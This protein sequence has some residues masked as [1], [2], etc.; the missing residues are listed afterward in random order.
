MLDTK[1]ITEK[2]NDWFA[3]NA[4]NTNASLEDF[5]G[6]ALQPENT[7]LKS[8]SY[9]KEQPAV[10]NIFKTP[11]GAFDEPAFNTYYGGL[12]K[13]YNEFS[14]EQYD[15]KN[16]TDNLLYSEYDY[17][18]PVKAKI[19]PYTVGITK[20]FNPSSSRI[21]I[22][23]FGTWSDSP[24]SMRE[25]AQ[26]QN[27]KNQKGEDLGF[28][29]NDDSKS[30]MFDFINDQLFG[31]GVK[32]LAQYTTDG[33]HI[34]PFTEES[35]SHKKGEMKYNEMGKPFYETLEGA[36]PVSRQILSPWD[37]ITNDGSNQ[38]KWNFMS[39]DDKDKS[40]TGS[41]M[42]S[43]AR[44][45]PY[46]V[47]GL[48]QWY[49]LATAALTA[50]E[51]TPQI[52][53]M[54]G[55]FV[56][57]DDFKTTD[58]YKWLNTTESFAKSMSANQVS[59]NSMGKIW[60]WE[61]MITMVPE[62]F[63]QLKQQRA[64][65]NIPKMLG[66][67]SAD[68]KQLNYIAKTKGDD[69]VKQVKNLWEDAKKMKDPG[70]E[71]M[72]RQL[73]LLKQSDPELLQLYQGWVNT[74]N[75]IAKGLSVGYMT[76]AS[77]GGIEEIV[78]QFDIS[79]RDGAWMKQGVLQAFW[80]EMNYFS[81]GDW[82]VEYAV[83]LDDIAKGINKKIGIASGEF[84]DILTKKAVAEGFIETAEVA[85]KTSFVKSLK[86]ISGSQFFKKGQELGAS[87]MKGIDSSAYLQ[88]MSKEALEEISEE[89]FTDGAKIVYNIFSDLNL[90]DTKDKKINWDNDETFARYA[91]SG[92]GGALG[93][94]LFHMNDA[95][96]KPLREGLNNDDFGKMSID[97]FMNGNGQEVYKNIDK[98]K[99]SKAGFASKVLSFNVVSKSEQDGVI[100]RIFAPADENNLSQNEVIANHLTFQAKH[101]E[102]SLFEAQVPSDKSVQDVFQQRSNSFI[103]LKEH[104]AIKDD[105]LKLTNEYVK[106]N[107]DFR[108]LSALDKPNPLQEKRT[109]ELGLEL[110][111]KKKAIENITSEE[112]LGK[113]Y[114]EALF[115][116]D[117]NLNKNY[118]KELDSKDLNKEDLS[119]SIYDKAYVNLTEEEKLIVD[120]E[121]SD[122]GAREK[123]RLVKI[124]FDKHAKL[125]GGKIK[126]INDFI[127]KRADIREKLKHIEFGFEIY[128]DEN[129]ETNID[130]DIDNTIPQFAN[131]GIKEFFN[132][133]KHLKGIKTLEQITPDIASKIQLADNFYNQANVLLDKYNTDSD[134]ISNDEY[135]LLQ[136]LQKHLG[137]QEI[138]SSISHFKT[139]PDFL[140]FINNKIKTETA[141]APNLSWERYVE[142]GGLAN[143]TSGTDISTQVF[144]LE[145]DIDLDAYNDIDGEIF[146]QFDK[147][148]QLLD[149]QLKKGEITRE[150]YSELKKELS[151]A[152]PYDDFVL[153]ND[154][155]KLLLEY[156][157]S[158]GSLEAEQI[159][160]QIELY[161][162]LKESKLTKSESLSQLEELMQALD[163]QY[164][165]RPNN[166]INLIEQERKRL[167]EK[168]IEEYILQSEITNK[169]ITRQQEILRRLSVVLNAYVNFSPDPNTAIGYFPALNAY[170]VKNNIAQLYDQLD[171][172]NAQ[173]IYEYMQYVGNRLVYLQKLSQT[174]IDSKIPNKEKQELVMNVLQ[175]RNFL[176]KISQIALPDEAGKKVNVFEA[177]VNDPLLD[178]IF[179]TDYQEEKDLQDQLTQLENK[180]TKGILTTILNTEHKIFEI[181]KSVKDADQF[182]D[183][184]VS[185]FNIQKIGT[186]IVDEQFTEYGKTTLN[187]KEFDQFIYQLNVVTGDSHKFLK[188]FNELM[189][190][191]PLKFAMFGDQ[192]NQFK[193][194]H[195]YLQATFPTN[196]EVE[197]NINFQSILTRVYTKL[198]EINPVFGKGTK[199]KQDEAGNFMI[200]DKI[201]DADGNK[202]TQLKADKL[203]NENGELHSIFFN[204]IMSIYGLQGT[205]KT[206]A[207]L[208]FI[209]KI[210]RKRNLN[211]I[212]VA[213]TDNV[214]KRLLNS[215]SNNLITNPEKQ[216]LTTLFET[217]FGEENYRELEKSLNN[218]IKDGEVQSLITDHGETLF[219][220]LNITSEVV[221]K[222]LTEIS[223]TAAKDL[224]FGE[225]LIK[226]IL[227]DEST[228]IH[229]VKIQLLNAFLNIYNNRIDNTNKIQI[230]TTGD[231]RQ[232][233]ALSKTETQIFNANAQQFF[234]LRTIDLNSSIRVE[235]NCKSVNSKALS[236]ITELYATTGTLSTS[237]QIN[238]KYYNTDKFAGDMGIDYK[239]AGND[240]ETLLNK[241]ISQQITEKGTKKDVAII[242]DESNTNLIALGR[243]LD[244]DVLFR[245]NVNGPEYAYTL[246][247]LDLSDL[248]SS[249]STYS[250]YLNGALT[251]SK[252]GSYINIDALKV[253]TNFTVNFIEDKGNLYD[254][255]IPSA[256]IEAYKIKRIKLINE[257]ANE[258]L[259]DQI[260]TDLP[261]PQEKKMREQD[262]SI[263]TFSSGIN[264]KTAP[265]TEEDLLQQLNALGKSTDRENESKGRNEYFKGY[266]QIQ[267]HH[268]FGTP[269]SI[270]EPGTKQRKLKNWAS[271][272]KNILGITSKAK[273]LFI[274]NLYQNN[275]ETS[276]E[277]KQQLLSFITANYMKDIEDL[278]LVIYE[279]EKVGNFD[280]SITPNSDPTVMVFA[281]RVVVRNDKDQQEYQYI[282]IGAL[283]T[284][285]TEQLR[286]DRQGTQNT[287][288]NNG[289][290]LLLNNDRLLE[291]LSPNYSLSFDAGEKIS[292]SE[293]RKNFKVSPIYITRKDRL[294]NDLFKNGQEF[295]LVSQDPDPNLTS[296]NMMAI[297]EEELKQ[298]LQNKQ[299]KGNSTDPIKNVSG[300]SSGRIKAVGLT[301]AQYPFMEWYDLI[302]ASRNNKDAL[303]R[304][305][306]GDSYIAASIFTELTR[307]YVRIGE[308]IAKQIAFKDDGEEAFHNFFG[309]VLDTM[310][311]LYKSDTNNIAKILLRYDKVQNTNTEAQ[312]LLKELD[313][314]TQDARSRMFKDGQA[315]H[316]FIYLMQTALEGG[317]IYK[318]DTKL[319]LSKKEINDTESPV[320]QALKMSGNLEG[321]IKLHMASIIDQKYSK[322]IYYTAQ[323][324]IGADTGEQ[325]TPWYGAQN[326]D[327]QHEV[328][329]S[330]S[331]MITSDIFLPMD[332]GLVETAGKTVVLNQP[333]VNTTAKVEE[334]LTQVQKVRHQ[335]DYLLSDNALEL[336]DESSKKYQTILTRDYNVQDPIAQLLNDINSQT[337]TT[338]DGKLLYFNIDSDNVLSLEGEVIPDQS[339]LS[340]EVLTFIDNLKAQ[341]LH[342]IEYEKLINDWYM[343]QDEQ[344]KRKL[345]IQLTKQMFLDKQ[346]NKV[347]PMMLQEELQNL[348]NC[349]GGKS[350]G[351]NAEITL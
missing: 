169:E 296:E 346:N 30:G 39:G 118:I 19:K 205:G 230:V 269:D 291:F 135:L 224:Y 23:G 109:K 131:K 148:V 161:N 3:A 320:M 128:E 211:T 242:T 191:E 347:W 245:S 248:K 273:T 13:S 298:G 168:P 222:I 188:D 104:T 154:P 351:S 106:L 141:F 156:Q 42:R 59:D 77:S 339:E 311:L 301:R 28:T 317:T 331:N 40:I 75:K 251:R 293:L 304:K 275:P 111:T 159:L 220:A 305:S 25:V 179:T 318:G 45:I 147:D 79:A 122:L 6:M 37:T 229:A 145:N 297:F 44:I 46:A 270:Q 180:Q 323:F 313:D 2:P 139:S 334:V 82:Q 158:K 162:K 29:P 177:I 96:S 12:V 114:A 253:F 286:K 259:G 187:V 210:Q 271:K 185:H 335:I 247:D 299:K 315:S 87:I 55:G 11:D 252:R 52:G 157:T 208:D 98:I 189:T 214:S 62:I 195:H 173:P 89:T 121:T 238:L 303:T 203:P 308:N 80:F 264:S 4:L 48:G 43:A 249:F 143:F 38:D 332:A 83:G 268:E 207:V 66:I 309:N 277:L 76:A 57:G 90:T 330:V 74:Q 51:F 237:A 280:K 170:N 165:S 105:L 184:F 134:A 196:F 22:E 336:N 64:I 223:K 175:F 226:L 349:N 49:A 285:L 20:I 117:A 221:S 266:D 18:A 107:D 149:K 239:S 136:Y 164:E 209:S 61:N 32:A 119:K 68:A 204:N 181:Q 63:I 101:T 284:K 295:V 72:Q 310:A 58:M 261:Q 288:M 262:K 194:I 246:V 123:L 183:E 10:Q 153:M 244:I 219:P 186:E 348:K 243:K 324:S 146:A 343:E 198:Q 263:I 254:I 345:W 15:L 73:A 151:Q 31:S 329:F 81:F 265:I 176:K 152:L 217:I 218:E 316:I 8:Q 33:T 24:L 88:S 302:K 56:S 110:Q 7:S 172:S 287:L 267:T 190:T 41:I 236:T 206:D 36:T 294:N 257:I 155:I 212:A 272:E 197:S 78:D 17:L 100:T 16:F 274:K 86:G 182:M 127:A 53:K 27:V 115:N 102:Q 84:K 292:L 215:V 234:N 340:D 283:T 250:R 326:V 130:M 5:K 228:Q 341:D 333:T 113:Y 116:M 69:Q 312:K 142:A 93:G 150:Q 99:N 240:Q 290:D 138:S 192:Q 112:S 160:K 337:L 281:M 92:I 276:Q 163:T 193:S 322:G 279:R 342:T 14:N 278:E 282:P 241:L 71:F 289:D 129:G 166:I 300:L 202:I 201:V 1:I 235:N 70:D 137:D 232:P 225:H 321:I 344:K 124:L 85:Q 9:Y 307:E 213:S 350:Q 199:P 314:L 140:N 167:L 50:A 200:G 47:P 26:T 120:T 60:T 54:I 233:G 227:I 256:K 97:L 258:L 319:T 328:H 103:E 35:V 178:P 325:K 338:V 91:M 126:P 125:L 95:F 108:S 144:E 306:L 65:G 216:N 255:S 327:S 67:T 94:V 133:S 231:W 260:I 171:Q 174:N 21:G 34:D 132:F